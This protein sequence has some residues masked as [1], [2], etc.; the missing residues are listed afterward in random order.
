M[1]RIVTVRACIGLIIIVE[2]CCAIEAYSISFFLF[3]LA[4]AIYGLSLKVFD[5]QR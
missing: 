5:H 4:Q 3:N 1:D 2:A